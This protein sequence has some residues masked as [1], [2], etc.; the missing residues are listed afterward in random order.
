VNQEFLRRFNIGIADP[1]EA[2]GKIILIENKR[3]TIVG[4]VKDFHYE[5]VEDKIL[6]MVFRYFTNPDY[7]YVNVKIFT[8][9]W[10]GAMQN[11]EAAWKKIDKVHPID[12]AFYDDQIKQAYSQFS[13]MI[14]VIGFLSFL[15][16]CIASMGLFG[17]VVFS[18]ETR[19]REISIRKVFGA[20]EWKLVL[21]LSRGF[22]LLLAL[23][24]IIALPA[25]YLFFDKV[26][27]SNFAYH[28]PIELPDML[29]GLLAVMIIAVL[30]L[31]SQTVK[32][33]RSNPAEVLKNE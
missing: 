30:M 22:I 32:V 28:N 24:A 26:I 1:V 25:T 23:A 3:L 29:S 14:K 10:Y 7:G 5:T 19:L 11:I 8:S 13:M 27:L 16:V 17:M 20:G 2:L 4:I 6:P 15:A 9:D 18:T 12:A 31:A 33:A 21:L